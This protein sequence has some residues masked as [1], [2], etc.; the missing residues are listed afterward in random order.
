MQET[1]TKVRKGWVLFAIVLAVLLGSLGRDGS[2]LMGERASAAG[3]DPVNLA[4]SSR[5][6]IASASST[7]SDRPPVHAN[8]G[9][10]GTSWGPLTADKN[11]G[12]VWLSLDFGANTAL[13]RVKLD[14]AVPSASAS[15]PLSYSIK[16]L[17]D[18][19]FTGTY[20][21]N[22]SK[23]TTV[24]SRIQSDYSSSSLDDVS[25]SKATTKKITVVFETDPNA[26]IP[27]VE[28]IELYEMSRTLSHVTVH[29]AKIV[30]NDDELTAMEVTGTM[31]DGGLAPLTGA[32]FAWSSSDNSVVAVAASGSALTTATAAS[33]GQT[34]ITA[35]LTLGGVTKQAQLALTVKNPALADDYDDLRKKVEASLIGGDNYNPNDSD[36]SAAIAKINTLAQ[37]VWESMNTS[38]TTNPYLWPDLT[39][40]SIFDAQDS[41]SRLLTLARSYALPESTMSPAT[42]T[43]VR[44][45]II[46]GITFLNTNWYNSTVTQNEQ[47]YKFEIGVPTAILNLTVLMYDDLIAQGKHALITSQMSTIH[48]FSPD[49]ADSR[50]AT[51]APRIGYMTGANLVEKCYNEALV[52]I[53]LKDTN[54]LELSG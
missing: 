18:A 8:D 54:A 32:T 52:G 24:A 53:L 11:T 2:L 17:N 10:T 36:I 5:G 42:K 7:S 26:F 29:A 40:G 20:D 12:E 46:E 34:S 23:W 48:H 50:S 25:F 3:T 22:P 9:N 21:D 38:M 1:K 28:E 51:S 44:N 30:L 15:L 6:T 49:P 43:A 14:F 47:W 13:D 37:P 19:A 39:T 31:S 4:A 27:R 16:I 35:S 45:A 33:P 41:Y